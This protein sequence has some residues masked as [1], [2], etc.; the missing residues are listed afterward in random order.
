LIDALVLDLEWGWRDVE[1]LRLDELQYWYERAL[2]RAKAR[3][4]G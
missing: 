4:N 1:D 3:E 2:K